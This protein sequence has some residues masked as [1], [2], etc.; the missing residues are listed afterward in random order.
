MNTN[1]S[2]D[3]K[4]TKPQEDSRKKASFSILKETLNKEEK[5]VFNRASTLVTHLKKQKTLKMAA[6]KQKKEED[7]Q[8]KKLKSLAEENDSEISFSLQTT[9][10]EE[11]DDGGDGRDLKRRIETHLEKYRY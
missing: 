7:R 3:D 11:E 5:F 1:E 8:N 4:A 6:L 10:E 9:S 2:I